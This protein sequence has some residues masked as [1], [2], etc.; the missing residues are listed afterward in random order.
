MSDPQPSVDELRAK[1]TRHLGWHGRRPPA[2]ISAEI[3]EELGDVAP[4]RYGEGGVVTELE[5]EVR[6]LLGK[7]AAVFMPSGTMAQQIALRVHADRLGRR[8]VLWHPT[9]HLQLHENEAP[10]RLH[11][12]QPRPVGDP[13]RLITLDDLTEVAEPVAALLL[14]LPQR[15]IGG[16]LPAW[17]D[18]VAQTTWAREAGAA[19]HLDGARL[20]E[21]APH[22]G[23]S[24]AEI[25]ALFDSVYVSLYKGI[26]GTAGCVLAGDEALVGAAREWRQRHGGTL[27]AMWPYAAAGLAG[28]RRR[29]PRMPAYVE[30]TRAIAAELSGQDGVEL[31]PDPPVTNMCHVYLNA[32]ADALT[33]AMRRLAIEDGVWTWPRAFP[34]DLPAWPVVE[35][36]IGDATM[37][38]SPSDV[39]EL[40]SGLLAEARRTSS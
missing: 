5:D 7:P 19:V 17:D 1:C 16:Q 25:A 20:W 23:R 24:L 35:L 27:F 14:E 15:E 9:C 39:R 34:S 11:G 13:R 6:E 32:P 4:D 12:L 2:E 22:Y 29:L 8:T 31:V 3:A 26:G 33:A 40:V 10:S 36:S 18:L 28:L 38:W 21:S 37:D 30:H